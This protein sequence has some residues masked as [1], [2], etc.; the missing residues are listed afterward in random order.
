[1]LVRHKEVVRY[2]LSHGWMLNSIPPLDTFLE[3]TPGVADCL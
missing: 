3:T 1:M 2:G